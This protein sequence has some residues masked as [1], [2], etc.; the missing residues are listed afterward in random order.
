MKKGE[1]R[2]IQKK[3]KDTISKLRNDQIIAAKKFYD[4]KSREKADFVRKKISSL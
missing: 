1:A 2:A 4:N 3:F